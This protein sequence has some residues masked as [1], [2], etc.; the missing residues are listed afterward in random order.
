MFKCFFK[1]VPFWRLLKN[2][3]RI[4]AELEE[5]KVEKLFINEHF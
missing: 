1:S 4:L 2:S 5:V 3:G